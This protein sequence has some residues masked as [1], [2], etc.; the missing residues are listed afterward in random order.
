MTIHFRTGD[1]D[2]LFE[3]LGSFVSSKSSSVSTDVRMHM[4]ES[5]EQYISTQ[6]K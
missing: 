6:Q 5:L 1:L 2:A 4:Y 3:Y